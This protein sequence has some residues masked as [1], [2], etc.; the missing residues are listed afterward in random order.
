[1]DVGGFEQLEEE[2]LAALG[3][4]VDVLLAGGEAVL[5]DLERAVREEPLEAWVQ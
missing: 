2:L 5:L 3:Q 4:P 1:V